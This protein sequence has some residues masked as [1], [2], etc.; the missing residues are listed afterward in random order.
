MARTRRPAARR[1]GASGAS[2][3]QTQASSVPPPS[4]ASD[5]RARGL[6]ALAAIAVFGRALPYP[7]QRSWDDGRFILDNT[8]VREPSLR[9]LGQIFGEQHFEAYHPLHLLGYWLDVPWFGP[10]PWVLHAVSLALWI[11]ALWLLYGALR[12]LALAPWA[13]VL[14]TLA[15]GLHPV[16]VEAVSWATGRKDVLALLFASASLW[17]HLR[18]RSSWDGSAWASRVAYALALLSK[19]TALPLPLVMITLDVLTGRARPWRAL[20]A[21]LPNLLLAAAASVGVLLIWRDHTMLRTTLGGPELAPLRFVQTLGHQLCTAFWPAHTAPMYST[22]SVV[23][24]DAGNIA[25]V[26]AWLAACVFSWRS[27]ARLVAAGL[28]AFGLLMLPVSNLV[29]MYFPLQ[30]R[31]LSLPLAGLGLA[32]AAECQRVSAKH[33]RAALLFV[34]ALIACL[35]L[36]TVQYAGVW[37]DEASLWGH[38]ASTQPDAEYAWLKLG[39]VRRE[40]GELE[41]AIAAYQAAVQTAPL[42]KLARAA[43]FEAVALRDERI[44]GIS[45]SQAR[46]LAQRFYEQMDS[47]SGLQELAAYL[48]QRGYVRS[49]ELPLQ[50]VLAREPLPDDALQKIALAQ[51]KQGR[52]SLARFYAANMKKPSEDPALREALAQYSLR[53]V[54]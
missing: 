42:R 22:E 7:L 1:K 37:R 10:V 16:Q 33:Q 25:A 23:R 54:P 17:L 41:A 36:R 53:V 11:G 15:C 29:P 28:I 40:S 5:W 43:L 30:D 20:L 8:A 52:G 47:G 27:G 18:A 45:P 51:L 46:A 4:A 50:I 44:A 13:A 9:A 14:G 2:Q 21:Q 34:G 49:L 38:A 26:V 6:I 48:L 24:L 32:L 39:E 35:G 31:Y 19:T 3:A 12:A